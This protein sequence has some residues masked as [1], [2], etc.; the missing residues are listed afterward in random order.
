M[1]N[2]KFISIKTKLL[3]SYFL[4]IMIPL[5]LFASLFYRSFSNI[6]LKQTYKS[7]DQVF[8]QSKNIIENRF[9]SL[10]RAHVMISNNYIIYD[11]LLDSIKE[12][13]VEKL[14]EHDDEI[15]E[16][17]NYISE[18]SQCDNISIFIDNQ[19]FLPTNRLSFYPLYSEYF[20]PWFRTVHDATLTG[21]NKIWCFPHNKKTNENFVSIAR[22]IYKTTSFKDRLAIIRMDVKLEKIL[23][24]MDKGSLTENSA[25]M[26]I[27]NNK[28]FIQKTLKGTIIPEAD[29]INNINSYPEDKWHTINVNHEKVIFKHKKII[30]P[31]WHYVSIIPYRDIMLENIILQ[32]QMI[33]IM[34]LTIV[35]I[36]ILAAIFTK[37]G[38]KNISD[39]NNK[40]KD[41]A[42]GNFDV[43]FDNIRYDEIGQLMANFGSM[44]KKLN[45]LINEKYKVELSAKN[46]EMKLLQAQ[47]NPHFLYNSLELINCIGIENDLNKINEMVHALSQFYKISLSKGNDFIPITEEI[48]HV[49]Y[50]VKIQNLRYGD[51][52]QLITDIKQDIH[53]FYIAKT[54]LQP[55]VENSIIHGILEKPSKNGTIIIRSYLAGSDIMIEIEDDGVGMDEKTVDR[56]TKFSDDTPHGYGLNNTN[57]RISLFYGD[58]YGLSFLTEPGKGT[59]VKIK[60]PAHKGSLT[61]NKSY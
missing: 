50:Y 20:K 5:F 57:R 27:Y 35:L 11:A 28:T 48:N 16:L 46:A 23:D 36:V 39:L 56:I 33:I 43:S 44:T 7:A 15:S 42:K 54:V 59:T 47:I 2:K 60:I 30:S 51:K 1:K 10:E 53:D 32:N 26:L 22:T 34:A 12:N 3:F 8:Y 19:G 29:I 52:I 45:N 31:G 49:G 18:T 61:T 17:M 40:M 13:N 58:K 55:I 38:I 9:H 14:L 21:S 4:L 24:I 25:V 6:V 41:V 37:S